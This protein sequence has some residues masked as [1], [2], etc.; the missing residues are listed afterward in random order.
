[1]MKPK[2]TIVQ[3]QMDNSKDH[4]FES[5]NRV[6]FREGCCPTIPTCAGGNI[7]PKTIRNF[8][9]EKNRNKTSN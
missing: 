4:T 3:G 8:K 7:Q 2:G 5:A 6:Y 1:M 9:N